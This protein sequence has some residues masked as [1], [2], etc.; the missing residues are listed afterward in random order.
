VYLLVKINGALGMA[1]WVMYTCL[2][3]L[4][5]FDRFVCLVLRK[6]SWMSLGYLKIYMALLYIYVF[7]WWVLLLIPQS[8]Y[9]PVENL[10]LAYVGPYRDEEMQAELTNDCMVIFCIVIWYLCIAVRLTF[11]VRHK[12]FS[13]HRYMSFQMEQSEF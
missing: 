10:G 4:I 7:G 1:C 11:D 12:L 8:S 3:G 2:V 5:A 13:N 9:L 6:K